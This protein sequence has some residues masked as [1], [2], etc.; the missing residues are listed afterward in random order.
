ME[1]LV[2]APTLFMGFGAL[3]WVPLSL[4]LGR[5]PVFLLVSVMMLL[6]TIGAGYAKDFRQLLACV[7]FIGLGEGF[8]LTC[9][10]S[11]WSSWL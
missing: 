6:A 3:L 5:R 1:T 8:S 2:T 9:V 4:G 11:S 10:C 7:C